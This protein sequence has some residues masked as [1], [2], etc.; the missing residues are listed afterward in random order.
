ME[1]IKSESVGETGTS[2][3]CAPAS[4]HVKSRYSGTADYPVTLKR[5][6]M[7][8]FANEQDEPSGP[9]RARRILILAPLAVLII[10]LNI[11]ALGAPESR[12]PQD[13]LCA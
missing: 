12:S 10:A 5:L 9:S 7:G 11:R 8:L 2:K 3:R 13:E 6:R 4:A 1:I